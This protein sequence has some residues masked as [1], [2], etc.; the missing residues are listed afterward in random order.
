MRKRSRVRV[1]IFIFIDGEKILVEKRFLQNFKKNHYLIPGG[2]IEG[3]FEDLGDALQR[4]LMEELGVKPLNY[5]LIPTD[6]EILGINGQLLTPFLINKWEGKLP[7][8]I[9][10]K[11]NQLTWLKIEELLNSPFEPTRKIAEALKA[12]ISKPK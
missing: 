2:E 7:K 5:N 4:E 8:K 3:Q 6:E 12:Y 1:V 11:G 10:D 9:L